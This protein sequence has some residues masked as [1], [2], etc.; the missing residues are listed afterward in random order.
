MRNKILLYTFKLSKKSKRAEYHEGIQLKVGLAGHRQQKNLS[1][2]CAEKGSDWPTFHCKTEEETKKAATKVVN[3][4][5]HWRI[6]I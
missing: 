1:S 5:L 4:K 6:N 2:E 3:K